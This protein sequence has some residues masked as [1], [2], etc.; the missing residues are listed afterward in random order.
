MRGILF[1]R[2]L[3]FPVKRTVKRKSTHPY[4]RLPAPAS[5]GA[6]KKR[7][8]AFPRMRPRLMLAFLVRRLLLAAPGGAAV[9]TLAVF[10]FGAGAGWV[11]KWVNPPVTAL[12]VERF[13]DSHYAPRPLVYRPLA[14]L[15]KA[16]PQCF[17][18]LEDKRFYTHHGVDPAALKNAY[19]QNKKWGRVIMGGSTIT[20]Q[21]VRTLFLSQ[22]R[23]YLRKY[24][25]AVMSLSLDAVTGKDRILE[26]YLNYIEWGK[27]VYGIGAAALYHYQRPVEKLTYEEYSR[28]AAIIINPIRYNVKNLFRQPAMVVRYNVLNGIA[29]ESASETDQ[30]GEPIQMNGHDAEE[31]GGDEEE[32]TV[33]VPPADAASG[34]DQDGAAEHDDDP[35]KSAA[36][37]S[38][39]SQASP[40]TAPVPVP[41]DPAPAEEINP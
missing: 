16:L 15:P 24:V 38:D 32:M 8:I 27:G 26:L 10:V 22:N 30:A 17:I 39:R 34:A 19:T 35:G 5:P 4:H 29:A 23:N 21:T 7:G 11:Y 31:P 13:L 36:P 18:R 2:C 1:S 12:M 25:E 40:D 33:A 3:H 14:G 9:F 28:L 41:P 20:Q 6:L 37:E